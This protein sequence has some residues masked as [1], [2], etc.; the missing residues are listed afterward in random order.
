MAI[1]C[2]P[3]VALATAPPPPRAALTG[4]VCR[5]ALDPPARVV[6]VT[7]VMRPVLGTRR[8]QVEFRLLQRPSGAR[9]YAPVAA[10]GL[11]NWVGP[12]DPTLGQRPGDVWRV[13]KPVADLAAPAAYRFSVVFRWLGSHGRVLSALTRSSRTCHQPELRPD[14]VV[15]GITVTQDKVHPQLDD[16]RARIDNRGATGAGPVTVRFTQGGNDKDKTIRYLGPREEESLTFIG[17]ACDPA[18]PPYVTADPD[19]EIDVYTRS[20]ATLAATCP[21]G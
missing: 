21:A 13:V 14:L 5:R 4:V 16:Y 9:G 3:A 10:A 6:S 11:G 19:Q 17:A 1:V 15:E 18:S 12:S 20:N 8:M 7:A 2:V